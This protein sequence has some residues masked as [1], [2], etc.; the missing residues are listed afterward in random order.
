[1]LNTVQEGSRH[2]VIRGTNGLR[3]LRIALRG[4]GKRGGG[5]VIYWYHSDGYPAVLLAVFAKNEASDLTA[6]Q[7][8]RFAA[9]GSAIIDQLGAK[10]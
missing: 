9:I 10:R 7:R 6:D 1:M 4:R 8:K 2:V 3:K 5:R